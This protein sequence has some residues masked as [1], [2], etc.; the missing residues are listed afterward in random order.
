MKYFAIRPSNASVIPAI[1]KTKSANGNIPFSSRITKSGAI[2]NLTT[3]RI[4]GM[5]MPVFFLVSI[6][7][8]SGKLFLNNCSYQ[9]KEVEKEERLK[10]IVK[11]E[12]R[13]TWNQLD[14]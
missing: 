12:I 7:R 6:E 3:L 2:R 4:F 13:L 8:G 11:M 9:K 10:S 5:L 1:V 14:F